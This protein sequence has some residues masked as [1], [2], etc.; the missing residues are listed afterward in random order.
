MASWLMD[1]G[2]R[3]GLPGVVQGICRGLWSRVFHLD[4]KCCVDRQSYHRKGAVRVLEGF[5]VELCRI[6]E[7]LRPKV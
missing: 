3:R 1:L 5:G 7:E 4:G 6:V 2:T